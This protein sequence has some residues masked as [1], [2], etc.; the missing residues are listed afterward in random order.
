MEV[1]GYTQHRIH[2]HMKS[3]K[4]KISKPRIFVSGDQLV[5]ILSLNPVLN[6]ILQR[7]SKEKAHFLVFLWILLNN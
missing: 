3:L 5:R 2:T 4:K 6:E 1:G 7:H